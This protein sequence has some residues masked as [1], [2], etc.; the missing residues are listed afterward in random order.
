MKLTRKESM[1]LTS[2][3]CFFVSIPFVLNIQEVKAM[4]P[5]YQV[6]MSLFLPLVILVV[7]VSYLTGQAKI[8]VKAIAGLSEDNDSN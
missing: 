2:F 4:P 3:F 5:I 7:T 8:D 1:T 6:V